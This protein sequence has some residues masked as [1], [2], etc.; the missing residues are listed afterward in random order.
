MQS[1]M[2]LASVYLRLDPYKPT[3]LMMPA[4]SGTYIVEYS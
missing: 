3:F 1:K 4:I 2:V